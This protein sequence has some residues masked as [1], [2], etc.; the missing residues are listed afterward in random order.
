ML[1]ASRVGLR[2]FPAAV[3]LLSTKADLVK[4]L[5]AEQKAVADAVKALG[6]TA[7]YASIK[8][9]VE[10][11]HASTM[12]K[13][14]EA[15]LSWTWSML[16]SKPTKQ[17]VTVA[18]VG[19]GSEVGAAALYRIAAGEMLGTD[20][21]VA[22]QLLGADASVVSDLEACGFPLLS[23]VKSATAAG[24]AVSGASYVIALEGDFAALGKAVASGA[25]GALVA[26]AGNTNALAASKAI[27]D[28]ASVTSITRAPQLAAELALAETAGAAPAA[29]SQVIS[30]GDGLADI[31]HA[32]V[33]GKWALKLSDAALPSLPDPSVGVAA[34][35]V[36]AHMKD[37]A[38][39]SDGKWVSMG[40]PA[41]GDYG[42]GEGFF[43]SVPVT[44]SPGEY[45]RVGGVTLTP[46]VAAAMEASR[47]ALMAEAA[48]L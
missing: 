44:C 39:G 31:S 2:R 15:D 45:K 8:A 4:G 26:V 38:C 6:P 37:W 25:K 46:E 47:T 23:G 48:K 43:F 41:V 40:V 19:A 1:A 18:V 17:P 24:A 3:R 30:W 35:A 34:D 5:A 36:V 20:Q 28:A 11:E 13:V 21:P 29:V 10:G 12:A 32:T 33:G 9:L 27:G 14:K 22:L 16:D 7:S 42:M